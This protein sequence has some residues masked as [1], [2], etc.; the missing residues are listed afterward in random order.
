MDD[1]PTR[2]RA[3][4]VDLLPENI[5]SQLHEMLRDKRNNQQ[6]IREAINALI[7][8]HNLDRKSVV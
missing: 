8:E 5:R 3:N 6:N 4:K 1:K 7:D 2:G